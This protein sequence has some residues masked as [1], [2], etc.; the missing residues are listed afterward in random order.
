MVR[1]FVSIGDV[2]AGLWRYVG[3][4][5]FLGAWGA[6]ECQ[7]D[8]EQREGGSGRGGGRGGQ[9]RHGLVS[10]QYYSGVTEVLQRCSDSMFLF[11]CEM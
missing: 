4:E 9:E 3:E 1:C 11:M 2:G 6:R 7:R 8:R 5:C 10:M